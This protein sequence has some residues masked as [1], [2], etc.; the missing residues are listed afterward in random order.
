MEEIKEGTVIIN[1]TKSFDAG[2]SMKNIKSLLKKDTIVLCL[3]NGLG[4][5]EKVKSE[6]IKLGFNENSIIVKQVR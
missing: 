6:L 3:Q 5:V 4:V 2:S 1:T